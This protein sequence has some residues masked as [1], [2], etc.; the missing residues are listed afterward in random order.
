MG[1]H[2]DLI[3][4]VNKNIVPLFCMH[5]LR[6]LLTKIVSVWL[7]SINTRS[8]QIGAMTSGER[9]SL[10]TVAVAV[11]A[12]GNA[13]PPFFVFPRKRYQ[14]HFVRDGPNGCVGVG[15]GSGW[16]KEKEFLEF[17]H[18]FARHAKPSL[19][20]KILL[21]LDNHSSHVT[22]AALDFCK[23][24]GI[25]ML[26]FP[27]HCTHRLQPLD[28]SVFRS[29]K[30]RLNSHFD[31]WMKSHPGENATIYHIPAIVGKA[32][33]QAATQE[34]IMAGFRC[35]GIWPY[36]TGIFNDNDFA[37]AF[38]TDRPTT[39]SAGETVADPQR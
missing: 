26:T 37:G 1:I 31:S 39:V 19:E 28:R 23:Q 5:F 6:K 4:S 20:S 17:L 29:F 38:A 27:A 30:G 13:I 11:N 7:T 2:Q 34:N 25:V 24:N 9:G 18:H 21:L 3:N 10:V 8:L 33:P 22:L 14:A 16:M 35:T 32:L 12:T 15:N 36:N